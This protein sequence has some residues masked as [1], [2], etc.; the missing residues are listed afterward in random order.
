MLATLN[1]GAGVGMHHPSARISLTEF[2]GSGISVFHP[3]SGDTP[4]PRR[5]LFEETVMT[6]FASRELSF[7]SFDDIGTTQN[8]DSTANCA[9]GTGTL[10]TPP[11]TCCT[12]QSDS[13]MRLAFDSDLDALQRQLRTALS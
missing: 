4:N 13:K 9:E 1:G 12:N 10:T 8:T 2:S 5:A 6:R 3:S 7:V 11:C